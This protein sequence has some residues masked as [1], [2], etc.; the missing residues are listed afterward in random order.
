MDCNDVGPSFGLL[1]SSLL[2]FCCAQKSGAWCLLHVTEQFL[3][4]DIEDSVLGA[5]LWDDRQVRF[6]DENIAIQ[7]RQPSSQFIERGGCVETVL[8]KA[9]MNNVFVLGAA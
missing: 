6:C 2:L 4:V 8:E 5:L 9:T 3:I 7:R 1:G